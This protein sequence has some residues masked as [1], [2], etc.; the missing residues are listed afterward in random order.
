MI[1]ILLSVSACASGRSP[2]PD[3]AWCR[4]NFPHWHTQTEWDAMPRKQVNREL[5]HNEFGVKKCGA[6]WGKDPDL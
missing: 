4:T 6:D 1:A 2:R 3:D 5:A